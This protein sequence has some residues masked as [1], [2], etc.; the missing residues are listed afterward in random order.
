[1]SHR[2]GREEP[3]TP[4][5]VMGITCHK[6]IGVVRFGLAPLDHASDGG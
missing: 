3:G 1:M 6:S 5:R 2:S 4:L